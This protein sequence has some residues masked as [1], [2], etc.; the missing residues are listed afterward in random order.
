[1]WYTPW[2]NHGVTCL[3]MRS[4]LELREGASQFTQ[5][6]LRPSWC[7]RGGL[8]DIRS[9]LPKHREFG[10]IHSDCVQQVLCKALEEVC[11]EKQY[12]EKCLLMLV[13][14]LQICN[15]S[16]QRKHSPDAEKISLFS[17]YHLMV[18]S[19][20]MTS[21]PHNFSIL[22]FYFMKKFEEFG[23]MISAND[24]DAQA[25]R[26]NDGMGIDERT[27]F[28]SEYV[29][30]NIGKVVLDLR[31]LGFTSIT[32]EAYA[33][34]IFSLLK[35][36]TLCAYHRLKNDS[37]RLTLTPNIGFLN[38]A[39]NPSS[40]RPGM[41][42]PSEELVRWQ[43][44]LDY[45]AYE[46]LQD[47]RIAKLFE[48]IVDYP[49]SSPAIED[50]KQCL[51]YTGQHSKLVDSFISSLRYRLLTAGASTNDIL[52]QYVSTIKAL[53]I[54]D[55]T[56][57]FLG[58]VGEP[59]REY[60]KG[61]KDTRKCI[62]SMLT[63]GPGENPNGPGNTEDNLLQELNKDENNQ[64]TGSCDDNFMSD[65]KQA[66]INAE[67]WE[68]DPVEADP[69]KDSR[70]RR[71]FDMLAEKLFNK[72]GYDIDSEIR[73]LELLKMC[74]IMLND[75]I[76]SK[77]INTNIKAAIS[78]PS[79]KA[80][81]SKSFNQIKTPRK[82]LWKKN[83]GTVKVELQF[84]YR[85]AQFVVS[86]VNAVIIM[87]FQD[88]P[89]WSSKDLAAAIGVPVD[90]LIRRIN[91]WKSKG[92][93]SESICAESEDLIFTLEDGMVDTSKNGVSS[94]GLRAEEEGEASVASQ[95]QLGE[96]NAVYEK[97]ITGMLTN[98]G[99]MSLE[100]THDILKRFCA[101]DKSVQHLK[102]FLSDLLS[103]EK[104]EVRDGLYHLRR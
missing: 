3:V 2:N 37:Y 95:E 21:L 4:Y 27:K 54:I 73:T 47:L 52:H 20:L 99:G 94:D 34:S 53:R 16:L 87:H 82:L 101:Y 88:Q 64:E 90:T 63:D 97:F 70:T 67:C 55:H 35:L 12:Q 103:E 23:T 59:I 15:E 49:D 104:L 65:E 75:F 45:F 6:S 28:S 93:I 69:L 62:V 89:S 22:R 68:P 79:Q 98:L 30:K 43:L 76:N 71:K 81:Y 41:D 38:L 66:W 100:Q 1:M 92:I 96:E 33:S 102:T 26:A 24:Y 46:T 11:S 56:G 39:S 9:R 57:V 10:I 13:N 74:E 7:L 29:V 36:K 72:A 14:A 86:P 80:D 40:F 25:N 78:H 18:S 58:E 5:H 84:G 8:R 50:L 91:F 17:R 44:L 61:R 48:I 32:E 51:S 31:S 42:I 85:T 83:L 19:V 60:L 77:R